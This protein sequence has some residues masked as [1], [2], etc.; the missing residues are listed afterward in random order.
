MAPCILVISCVGSDV[1]WEYFCLWK[2][3]KF[4]NR[5]RPKQVDS[6]I[7]RR[8]RRRKRKRR[9]KRR[10]RRRRRRKRRRRRRRRRRRVGGE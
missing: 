5:D 8:R 9:R 10:R 7:R 6:N 1:V 4:W 3:T 2:S